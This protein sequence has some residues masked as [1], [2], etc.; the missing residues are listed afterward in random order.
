VGRGSGTDGIDVSGGDH[1][2]AAAGDGGVE[3][4]L[5]TADPQLADEVWR[6]CVRRWL[7]S[8]PRR[9]PQSPCSVTLA[10]GMAQI[11]ALLT[12]VTGSARDGS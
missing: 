11:T 9:T 7:T 5:V 2:G 1:S 10:T 3:A 12:N 4:G 8:I 6:S